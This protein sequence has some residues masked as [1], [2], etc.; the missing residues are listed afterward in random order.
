MIMVSPTGVFPATIHTIRPTGP[1]ESICCP[2]WVVQASEVD[3]VEPIGKLLLPPEGVSVVG[4]TKEV[5]G[6]L[7]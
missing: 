5:E 1:Q 4:Y 7:K 6:D 3:L 2:Q